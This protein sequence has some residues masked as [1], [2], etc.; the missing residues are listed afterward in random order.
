MYVAGEMFGWETKFPVLIINWYDQELHDKREKE[1]KEFDIKIKI[2]NAIKDALQYKYRNIDE[3]LSQLPFSI[4]R[5][6]YVSFDEPD[7]EFTTKDHND[8]IEIIVDGVSEFLDK[9][10]IKYEESDED[11][12]DIDEY[13]DIDEEDFKK[14][15]KDNN[16]D[17]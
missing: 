8:K 7:K 5:A 10:D 11:D 17:F 4:N 3:L 6:F 12:L 1:E 16:L 9:E 13:D 14:W 15:L 2:K